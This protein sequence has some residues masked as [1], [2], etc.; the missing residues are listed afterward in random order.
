MSFAGDAFLNIIILLWLTIAVGPWWVGV[1]TFFISFFINLFH[2]HLLI[3]EKIDRLEK[4]AKQTKV[5]LPPELQ[6]Q[7]KQLRSRKLWDLHQL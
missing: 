2:R 1:L 7:L 3:K 6:Q 4:L 5:K